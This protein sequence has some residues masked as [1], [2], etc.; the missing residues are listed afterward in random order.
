MT[1]FEEKIKEQLNCSI[2]CDVLNKPKVLPCLHSFCLKCLQVLCENKT[3]I[4]CPDCRK[5]CNI[6]NGDVNELPNDFF[7]NSLIDQLTLITKKMKC[8]DCDEDEAYEAIYCCKNCSMYLCDLH[9]MAHK[10]GKNTKNHSIVKL[11]EEKKIVSEDNNLFQKALT[12]PIYCKKHEYEIIRLYCNTCESLICRDCAL[13]DHYNHK[14]KFLPEAYNEHEPIIVKS[15][16]NTEE[17]ENK[18]TIMI[19]EVKLLKDKL[20]L[21]K[22]LALDKSKDLFTQLK[23]TLNEREDKI[24]NEILL[25]FKEKDKEFITKLNELE[26]Q[27]E[28]IKSSYNYV[29]QALEKEDKAQVLSMKKIFVNRLEELNNSDILQCKTN[30][31]LVFHIKNDILEIFKKLIDD[32]GSVTVTTKE[33]KSNLVNVGNS[34]GDEWSSPNRNVLSNNLAPIVV[35]KNEM[36]RSCVDYNWLQPL[37]KMKEKKFKIELEDTDNCVVYS[38]IGELPP[39]IN[40]NNITSQSSYSAQ[41]YFQNHE[42]KIILS[43]SDVLFITGKNAVSNMYYANG[44]GI[45]ICKEGNIKD[46]KLTVLTYLLPNGKKK[47]KPRRHL[48]TKSHEICFKSKEETFD[49]NGEIPPFLG[50]LKIYPLP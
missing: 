39:D 2:C 20:N 23:Q 49:I 34:V 31:T 28:M 5:E 26:T 45:V 32:T 6:P 36:D 37:I 21:N 4:H 41:H 17:Y 18:L 47:N 33:E 10:K 22:N 27:L 25:K 29:K 30:D 7:K 16:S 42:R 38:A 8:D 19:N 1:S 13:V 40:E 35:F 14:F 12:K 50:T 24:T 3:L 44:Y 48:W 9:G 46:T 11:E 43:N 15:L